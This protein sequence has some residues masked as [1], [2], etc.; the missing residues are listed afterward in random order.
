MFRLFQRVKH[1]LN[2][3]ATRNVSFANLL[4]A[5]SRILFTRNN[6][7]RKDNRGGIQCLHRPIH[8]TRDYN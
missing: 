7:R 2:I 6:G 1:R 4:L 8:K 3:P 5:A